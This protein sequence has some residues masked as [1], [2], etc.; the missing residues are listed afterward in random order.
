MVDLIKLRYFGKYG[1]NYDVDK[2]IGENSMFKGSN[3]TKV[4]KMA[5]E[6]DVDIVQGNG[7]DKLVLSRIVVYRKSVVTCV[8]CL[9]IFR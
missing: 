2:F 7:T 3:F 5:E 1:I 8:P 9:T 6:E 4:L